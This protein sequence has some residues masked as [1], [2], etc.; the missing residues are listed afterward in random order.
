MLS[1][2]G[3]N[4]SVSALAT[5]MDEKMD[6]HHRYFMSSHLTGS[7]IRLSSGA[8]AKPFMLDGAEGYHGLTFTSST[9]VGFPVGFDGHGYI[10]PVDV[11]MSTDTMS[12]VAKP[13]MSA[14]KSS[15]V[16]V[17]S[18]T[19][20]T[21][22]LTSS[23][24]PLA[25][26]SSPAGNSVATPHASVAPE[27]IGA[28]VSGTVSTQSLSTT[29]PSST[30]G[31]VTKASTTLQTSP[32]ASSSSPSSSSEPTATWLGTAWCHEHPQCKQEE[33]KEER[34]RG[35]IAGSVIGAIGFGVLVFAVVMFVRRRRRRHRDKGIEGA[36]VWSDKSKTGSQS[37]TNHTKQESSED[38]VINQIRGRSRERSLER[39]GQPGPAIGTDGALEAL[40]R[41]TAA[42]PHSQGHIHNRSDSK[43]SNASSDPFRT[44]IDE[45]FSQDRATDS[46]IGLA[47]SRY[48]TAEAKQQYSKQPFPS[49]H[50]HTV[51]QGTLPPP[52]SLK[53]DSSLSAHTS[54]KDPEEPLEICNA[55]VVRTAR[56]HSFTPRI[57]NIVAGQSTSQERI[58]NSNDRNQSSELGRRTS[59]RARSASPAKV[60]SAY[61]GS[62]AKLNAH[63]GIETWGMEQ[64]RTSSKRLGINRAGSGSSANLRGRKAEVE[65]EG[66]TSYPPTSYPRLGRTLSAVKRTIRADRERAFSGEGST[67]WASKGC[68]EFREASPRTGQTMD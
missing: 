15:I 56:R 40:E 35:L 55:R 42:Y 13:S 46:K 63:F 29:E 23:S 50:T 60:L 64:G 66:L 54:A 31:A 12:T 41:K 28:T 27:M 10:T 48:S 11:E 19:A 45:P 34:H 36:A 43:F 25:A 30:Q 8:T 33:E 9:V 6:S 4:T 7:A 52:T 5:M 39:L 32:A 62:P 22:N 59:T 57:I 1:M 47:L 20:S 58:S 49:N 44:P 24:L 26:P 3:A 17:P 61:S 2:M 37:S 68:D 16:I 38:A 51:V 18:E 67:Q 21:E 53:R 14:P 65:R